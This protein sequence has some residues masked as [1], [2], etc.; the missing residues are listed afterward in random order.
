MGQN[1][2][3]VSHNY[4]SQKPICMWHITKRIISGIVMEDCLQLSEA[5]M[6]LS[7]SLPYGNQTSCGLR[8]LHFSLEIQCRAK[9]VLGSPHRPTVD[10]KKDLRSSFYYQFTLDVFPVT[11]DLFLF[12]QHFL[13]RIDSRSTVETLSKTYMPFTATQFSSLR[14]EA[15]A[16]KCCIQPRKPVATTPE[17]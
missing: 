17:I 7:P 12:Y 3:S 10:Y 16:K 11:F 13:F 8:E 9:K 1:L 4:F 14:S 15:P 6:N 5:D 2:P